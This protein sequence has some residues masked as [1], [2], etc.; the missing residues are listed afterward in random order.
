MKLKSILKQLV[1][2]GL[3]GISSTASAGFNFGSPF[4]VMNNNDNYNRYGPGNSRS[5]YG[6]GDRWSQ[7][8][9]WEPN[10]WRYRYMD[11]NSRDNIFD[12]FNG[13]SYNGNRNRAR[14]NYDPRSRY[15]DI[16]NYQ[17]ANRYQ[18]ERSGRYDYD[19]PAP[20]P[21]SRSAYAGS[22]PTYDQQ[23]YQRYQSQSRGANRYRY[24]SQGM[25]DTPERAQQRVQQKT[26]QPAECR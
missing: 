19:R 4:D 1:I 14:S 5:G 25:S 23:A 3:L 2:L 15:D 13:Q 8:D 11:S 17:R 20:R 6:G 9:Q 7:Y 10:Y 18:G 21:R 24:E 22:Q 16:R 12:Q 26:R